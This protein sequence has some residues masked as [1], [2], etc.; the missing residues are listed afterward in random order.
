[1]AFC[2]NCGGK[3]EDGVKFCPGCGKAAGGAANESAAPGSQNQA[4]A[5]QTQSITPDD[6][7][8]FSCGSVIKKAAEICP[9]CGVKQNTRSSTTAINVYCASCGKSIKKE[10]F[11]CPFC[12][13]KQEQENKSNK[14]FLTLLLLSIFMGFLGVDRFYAGKI[15]SGFVKFFTMGGFCIWWFIDIVLIATGKFTDSKGNVIKNDFA[16]AKKDLSTAKNNLTAIKDKIAAQKKQDKQDGQK[17]QKTE[18]DVK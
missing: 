5:V 3:I 15:G 16:A 2:S 9:K 13:V 6:K 11:V 17:D 14:S 7:Y 18:R 1:M 12:G 10:A 8:C 4:A